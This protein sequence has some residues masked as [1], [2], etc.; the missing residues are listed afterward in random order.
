VESLKADLESGQLPRGDGW[1]GVYAL[2]N[3]LARPGSGLRQLI[4]AHFWPRQLELA[5]NGRIYRRLGVSLFGRVIPTGG[6]EVRRLTRTKMAPYTLRGTS[7]AAARDFYYR[8]CIFEAL[9]TPFMLALLVI[10][11]YQYTA[12]RPDL[13]LQ[14]TLVNLGVNIYPMMHHRHTRVRIVRLLAKVL[15][16]RDPSIP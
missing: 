13:A 9:H 3:W 7:V 11:G 4:C 12:G 10:A 6:V 16:R 5:G 2:L 14:D 15:G 8:T 1:G